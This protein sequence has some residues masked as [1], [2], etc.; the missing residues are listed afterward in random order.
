[1][2]ILQLNKELVLGYVPMGTGHV[3]PFDQIFQK[4]IK[5]DPFTARSE[6]A[7]CDAI[8]VWGGQDI[9]PSLYNT[10]A[11]KWTGAGDAPSSR[12]R[13]EAASMK[14]AIEYGVPI[15]GVCRGAQ[16]ACALAGGVLV[17]HVENHGRTH[18][19]TT[20]DGRSIGTSSVHHQMMYPFAVEHDLIAWSSEVRSP[21]HMMSDDVDEKM[22]V[23][24]EIVYFPKIKA[25]AIQGHPEFMEPDCEFVQYCNGLVKELLLVEEP[26]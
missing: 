21:V 20:K 5:I 7:K 6:I 25:L 16:L 9:S 17:Q 22:T 13:Y 4:F 12:D 24:P 23:E 1:M 18:F 19:I 11:S 14:A 10:K 15:I 8:V 26:A 3:E 2:G